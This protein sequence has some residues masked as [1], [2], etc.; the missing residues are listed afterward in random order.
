[1]L[2]TVQLISFG[3]CLNEFE[4]DMGRWLLKEP[5]QTTCLLMSSYTDGSSTMEGYGCARVT[6]CPNEKM[7]PQINFNGILNS[8]NTVG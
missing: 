3:S 1:M 4:V 5:A 2:L 7:I 8:S 6:G